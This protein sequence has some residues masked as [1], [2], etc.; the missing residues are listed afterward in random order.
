[1]PITDRQVK[2]GGCRK[3]GARFF[4]FPVSQRDKKNFKWMVSLAAAMAHSSTRRHFYLQ[5]RESISALER[6]KMR[7]YRKMFSG[8]SKKD[9]QHGGRVSVFWPASNRR[10]C[11]A[12]VWLKIPG[13]ISRN[14]FLCVQDYRLACQ[15]S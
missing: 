7:G 11:S 9:Y 10:R 14:S 8:E 1:M 4:F 5:T 15:G 12:S 13:L 6:R 3:V 2:P